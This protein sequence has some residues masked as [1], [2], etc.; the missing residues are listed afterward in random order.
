M[1]KRFSFCAAH[2]QPASAASAADLHHRGR[3]GLIFLGEP[4]YGHVFTWSQPG[5][6][7]SARLHTLIQDALKTGRAGGQHDQ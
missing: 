7:K 6:G 1:K 3:P 5:A 4:P 2:G